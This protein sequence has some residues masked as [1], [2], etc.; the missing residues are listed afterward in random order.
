MQKKKIAI[1][2]ISVV[3]IAG[4]IITSV[5]FGNKHKQERINGTK[6]TTSANDTTTNVSSDKPID[7]SIGVS[8]GK[9][10]IYTEPGKVDSSDTLL[11]GQVVNITGEDG[12]YYQI[13]LY[14]A[15]YYILK[16][17]VL[18]Y[19]NPYF[20]QLGEPCSLV[21]SAN[22]SSQIIINGNSETVPT[23]S[24]TKI[25]PGKNDFAK[26][27]GNMSLNFAFGTNLPIIKKAIEVTKNYSTQYQKAQ[28]LYVW[29]ATHIQYAFAPYNSG[30]ANNINE[31][32]MVDSSAS[33]IGTL[34]TKQ[35]LC[36]GY[37]RLY[38]ALCEAVGIPVRTVSNGSYEWNQVNTGDGWFNV[39]VTKAA[40]AY[41]A[42]S[43]E[44]NNHIGA[45]G[46]NTSN[47]EV[48]VDPA[49]NAKEN[50]QSQFCA[51]TYVYFNNPNVFSDIKDISIVSQS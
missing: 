3:V 23:N 28:A 50:S 8:K 7:G 27:T 18:F 38:S 43:V 21:S 51:P 34:Q 35:G 24:L 2:V 29:E 25:T 39:D 40:G 4:V 37:S 46:F 32:D 5:Y 22:G 6:N 11:N 33:T 16:S 47:T 1:I 42:S 13:Y 17:D 26:V 41:Y 14:G 30:K 12:G 19:Q 15:K 20:T 31:L 48:I 49:Y 45:G 9:V 10:N 36:T 44:D